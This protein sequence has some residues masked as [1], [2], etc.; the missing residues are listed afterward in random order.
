MWLVLGPVAL[1][2][3]ILAVLW[4]PIEPVQDGTLPGLE[5]QMRDVVEDP[6]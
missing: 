1:A 3:L 2:G 5:P 4:R 6:S